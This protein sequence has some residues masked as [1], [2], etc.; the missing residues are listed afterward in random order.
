RPTLFHGGTLVV[1]AAQFAAVVAS[2][3]AAH[4]AVTADH[5]VNARL[6]DHRAVVVHVLLRAVGS[7]TVAVFGVAVV[8]NLRTLFL[9]ITT[10]D[11]RGAGPSLFGAFIVG[12]D[13]A[14]TAA[15]VPGH[16]VTIVA[17]F[18]RVDDSVATGWPSITK[19]LA[20]AVE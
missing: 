20:A 6:A 12:L 7:A 18:A 19:H 1:T 17:L 10:D 14:R 11:G 3:H 5:Q 2:L 15:T 4:D 16:R 13:A 9:T 8:T